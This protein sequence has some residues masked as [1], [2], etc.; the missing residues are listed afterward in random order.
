MNGAYIHRGTFDSIL[1]YGDRATWLCHIAIDY[2]YWA[3]GK[4]IESLKKEKKRIALILT[5]A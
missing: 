1:I 3:K 4:N 2:D 5:V